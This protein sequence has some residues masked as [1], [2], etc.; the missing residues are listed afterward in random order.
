MRVSTGEQTAENQRPALE[1]W[2][3]DRGHELVAV[4][5][6]NETA[7]RSGHQRELAKLLVDIRSGK[8]KYD[9]LLV[10]ALDRLSRGG[11]AAILNLVDTFHVYNVKVVSFQESWTEAPGLVGEIMYAIAGWVAKME[12]ERRSERTKAG[13]ARARGEGQRL[14][15]PVGSKD[16]KGRRRAG[17]LLRYTKQRIGENHA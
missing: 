12:S 13:L 9:I 2:C 4:Y 3:A 15:R 17:Y 14:G 16:K 5:S 6:E 8:R 7:W 10:W 11:A 1:R